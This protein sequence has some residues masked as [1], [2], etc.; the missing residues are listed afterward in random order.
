MRV[1]FIILLALCP[2]L[3]SSAPPDPP[4][5]RLYSYDTSRIVLTWDPPVNDGGSPIT[6]VAVFM[7]LGQ[8]SY[9]QI[10]TLNF[11]TTMA[12]LT[13]FNGQALQTASYSLH[14]TA[15]NAYGASIPSPELTINLQAP[16]SPSKSVF[17]DF[18]T[19]IIRNTPFTLTIQAYDEAGNKKTTGGDYMAIGIFDVC[20]VPGPDIRCFRISAGDP[21]YV[22]DILSQAIIRDLIDNNDGTYSYT[23][24]VP[25]AGYVTVAP[26]L[27]RQGGIFTDLYFADCGAPSLSFQG[28]YQYATITPTL[29]WPDAASFPGGRNCMFTYM[30]ARLRPPVT[31]DYVFYCTHDD[32]FHMFI[33]GLTV[34]SSLCCTFVTG[35]LHM[36]RHQVYDVFMMFNEQG[37]GANL[38]LDWSA[39][40]YFGQNNIPSDF[41]WYPIR[42]GAKTY[43]VKVNAPPAPNL[44]TISGLSPGGSVSEDT[45]HS[46]Q[47][48]TVWD[49]ALTYRVMPSTY[50]IKIIGPSPL[51]TETS[52]TATDLG[53][54]VYKFDYTIADPGQYQLSIKINGQHIQNSPLSFTVYP[55]HKYCIGCTG[56][57]NTQCIACNP[58]EEAYPA[59]GVPTT[60]DICHPGY[61]ADLTQN[62]CVPCDIGEYQDLEKEESCKKCETGTYQPTQGKAS[63][64]IC[65]VGKVQPIIGQ[66]SCNDCLVG[67]YMSEEGKTQCL[68]CPKGKFNA[69]TGQSVCTD[70]IAGEYQN[71][72]G[73]TACIPCATGSY[74][75]TP[76]YVDCLPCEAGKY[77]D[78]QGKTTCIQ[79]DPGYYMPT[80]GAAICLFCPEGKYSD[81]FGATECKICNDGWYPNVNRNGC[82]YK[83]IF[84]DEA[85]FLVHPMAAACYDLNRKIIKPYTPACRTAYRPI[86]CSGSTK[87]TSIDCNF[88]LE[89]LTNSMR[90]KFCSACTFMDQTQCPTDGLCWN[91]ATWTDNN[92]SPYPSTFTPNCLNTISSYCGS[93]L[94]YNLNDPECGQI[95]GSCLGKIVNS[96]YVGW[97]TFRITFDKAIPATLPNCNYIFN[98]TATPIVNTGEL[99]CNRFSDYDLDV[100]VSKL[101]GPLLNFTFN[102]DYLTDACGIY[103]KGISLKSITPPTPPVEF[104]TISGSSTDKCMGLNI[105]SAV[106]VFFLQYYF[107]RYR[108]LIFGLFVN[109]SGKL[110]MQIQVEFLYKQWIDCQK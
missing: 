83:G 22:P 23:F 101:S 34:I 49:V 48:T 57:L 36:V 64:I 51:I 39:N 104:L 1:V 47:I 99:T 18:P 42:M 110:F 6:S 4:S 60:C 52:Y 35:G 27:F 31:A 84:A 40:G 43:E 78:L 24:T 69:N 10:A 7:K 5:I 25:Q 16:A 33:N 11:A 41:W 79:C 70:C 29:Y 90:D 13:T 108:N 19:E 89:T 93:K 107:L 91:D 28:Y 44:C 50:E 81:T 54:Y 53:N 59:A 103:L 95:V 58:V 30:H 2:F 77:Q 105:K 87:S 88:G 8:G 12:T 75:P 56:V 26:S 38:F 55:C 86:C 17:L 82:L 102:K 46:I 80:T 85:A 106:L 15:T 9:I 94:N 96:A 92:V 32:D 97:E 67:E 21:H 68:P 66:T 73:K 62:L 74:S 3:V 71:E 76:G 61:R 98:S 72:E 109:I 100:S 37:G 45:V 63:C 20:R 14:A 65:P